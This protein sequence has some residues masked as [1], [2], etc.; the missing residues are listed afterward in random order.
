MVERYVYD[1][2]GAVTVLTPDWSVRGA[3]AYGWLYL[4]QGKRYDANVGLYDSRRGCT[5]RR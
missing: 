4:W 5:R 1:P 2:Y 3:S